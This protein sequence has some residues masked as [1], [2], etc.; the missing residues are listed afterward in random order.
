M[1][2]GLFLLI[3]V[4]A[5]S[6]LGSLVPQGRPDAWYIENYQNTGQLVVTLGVHNL[7]NQWYFVML[8]SM[9]FINILLCCLMRL[10]TLRKTRDNLHLAD[11]DSQNLRII[12]TEAAAGLRAYLAGNR[13]RCLETENGAIYYKNLTGYYGSFI[14]HV[15]MLFILVFGG[16]VLGLSVTE[17][18]N[19][20]LGT[21]LRLEDGTVLSLDSFRVTDETGRLDYA[22]I[23]RIT[24]ADGA[25]SGPREISVN[26]PLTFKS[27]KY[28]QYS[29]GTAGALSAVNTETGGFDAFYLTE[30]SFLS[31]D[32]RNGI[33]YEALFPGYVKDDEGNITPLWSRTN[34]YPDPIYHVMVAEDGAR[35]SRMA[36]PGEIIEISGIAFQFHEPVNFPG[37]RVKHIPQPFPALLYASF[38]LMI[39]GFWLC[40]FHLPVIV[41]VRSDSY[42]IKGSDGEQLKIEMFLINDNNDKFNV[43]ES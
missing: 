18:H 42:G 11:V 40:F 39:A 38:I 26:Y 19:L 5:C 16:L 31:A 24:A 10:G 9:L 12:G 35:T 43:K 3:L 37:I 1:K 28:Y 32:G 34:Y 41:T 27:K 25:Q 23:L 4:M 36:L 33:W 22:S 21:D 17:D 6:L 7:F 20:T 14:V 2:F 8:L 30:R 13:Y 15:S 29:Y